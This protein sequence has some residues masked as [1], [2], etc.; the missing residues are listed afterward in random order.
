MWSLKNYQFLFQIEA[1]GV[2]EVKIS[3]GILLITHT[4]KRGYIPFTL[5]ST[6]TGEVIKE[7]NQLVHRNRPTELIEAFNEFLILKQKGT[8]LQIIDVRL[9]FFFNFIFLFAFFLFPW[10]ASIQQVL[11]PFPGI[12]K[13]LYRR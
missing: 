12:T 5:L 10:L 11:T 13:Y 4:A 6:E 9:S 2:A 3:P 7:F 8:N 1:E